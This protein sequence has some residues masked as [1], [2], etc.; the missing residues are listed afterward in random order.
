MP[1][2]SRATTSP[3]SARTCLQSHGRI[4]DHIVQDRRDDNLVGRTAFDQNPRHV[5]RMN[6]IRKR[7]RLAELPMM[8]PRGKLNRI[9]KI[10][11]SDFQQEIRAFSSPIVPSRTLNIC[12]KPFCANSAAAV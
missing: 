8:R 12:L 1:L 4:F 9:K 3:N 7:R 11:M 5:Q 2:T 6:D 10:D